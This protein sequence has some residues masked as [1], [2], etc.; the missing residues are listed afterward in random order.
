MGRS[1][2]DLFCFGL[3]CF[4]LSNTL[5]NFGAIRLLF[6]EVLRP[7]QD[8][9][10]YCCT[11]GHYNENSDLK[12]AALT[13]EEILD[14]INNNN[15]SGIFLKDFNFKEL[16]GDVKYDAYGRIVGDMIWTYVVHGL[17]PEI[18]SSTP[19]SCHQLKNLRMLN[20]LQGHMQFL[21]T[22]NAT[23][24]NII[25]MINFIVFIIILIM[26]IIRSGI[27]ADAVFDNRERDCCEAFWNC[28]KGGED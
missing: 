17:G 18:L 19:T 21:T 6:A 28:H 3:L 8:R 10:D 23:A 15:V 1:G 24:L 7:G 12:M 25:V 22:V 20:R 13:E 27:S 4:A 14:T 26:I 11:Q 9:V 16:L 5:L 2:F